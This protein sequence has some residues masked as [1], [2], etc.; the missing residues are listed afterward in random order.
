MST[1]QNQG[2]LAKGAYAIAP[3]QH[4]SK[5]VKFTNEVS[6]REPDEVEISVEIFCHNGRWYCQVCRGRERTRPMGPYT[7]QQAEQIQDARRMLIARLGSARLVFENS[8]N[9]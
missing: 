3:I 6:D 1:T 4:H 5:I 7:K 8:W 2:N 9:G